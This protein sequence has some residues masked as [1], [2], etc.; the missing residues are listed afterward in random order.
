MYRLKGQVERIFLPQVI[1][2]FHQRLFYCLKALIMQGTI[3]LVIFALYL[4]MAV[5]P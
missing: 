1:S 4:F 3:H 2:S 5:V